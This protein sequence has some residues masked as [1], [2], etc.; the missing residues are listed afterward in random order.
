MHN[1]NGI[2]VEI[3]DSRAI[4]AC[5]LITYCRLAVNTTTGF[6]GSKEESIDNAARR[7]REGDMSGTGL[8]TTFTIIRGNDRSSSWLSVPFGFLTDEEL[9]VLYTKPNL[10]PL[11]ADVSVT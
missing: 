7:S 9:G 8:G 10:V 4:V 2:V 11:L 1:F 3:Q 6:Q 5:F